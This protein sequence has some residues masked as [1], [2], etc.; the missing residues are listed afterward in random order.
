[1]GE[2]AHLAR[3]LIF[4]ICD[5]IH[6]LVGEDISEGQLA[7]TFEHGRERVGDKQGG[8]PFA[9]AYFQLEV[10]FAYVCCMTGG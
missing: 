8:V 9:F 7:A 1:M 5:F 10:R 2:V 4:P 6:Q 3:A